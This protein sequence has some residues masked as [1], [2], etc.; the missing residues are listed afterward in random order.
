MKSYLHFCRTEKNLSTNTLE[1][2]R[3]DLTRFASFVGARGLDELTLADLRAYADLLKANGLSNRSISRHVTTMRGLFQFAVEEGALAGNPAELLSS[4]AIG[5]SLPKYLPGP[6]VDQLLDA[7]RLDSPTGLR[8]RAMV[9]LLYA[10]GMR[11]SE[12]IALRVA[13][14]DEATG[15][16]RVTGKG[17]KQ[18]LVPVGT[19]ALRTVSE[20]AASERNSLL[21][22]RMSPYLFVTARGTSMTR[23]AFWKLLR[24]R[25]KTAGIF[26][27]L[28]PHV[29][30]HTF[31]THLLEGGADLRS[32]QT[33][34]GH[35]DIGT[36]QIYT[37]VL[38]SRLEQTVRQHHPRNKPRGEV[39]EQAKQGIKE[40][41]P[42]SDYMFMLDSHLSSEQSRVLSLV[43]DTAARAN[44]NLFLTGGAMR[45]M[46]GG[47]AIRDLDFTVEGNALKLAKTIAEESGAKILSLDEI[48]NPWNWNFP[49]VLRQRSPWR[50][51]KN[52]RNREA[53][54]RFSRA[55]SMKTCAAAISRSTPSAC[56][57]V[58][59]RMACF[60]I[61]R[62]GWRIWNAKELQAVSNYTLYDDPSR[63]LRLIRFRVRLSLQLSE[64]TMSQY[65][66]VREAQLKQKS[67]RSLERELRQIAQEP[68]ALEILQALEQEKL[69]TLFR[70]RSPDPS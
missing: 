13:D 4:P 52:I 49:A 45:D 47:F 9:D 41:K 2:Y 59:P 34:L 21:K 7:S 33:M 23:Q 28:S 20:Y 38:R 70:P 60:S 57:S 25:G 66:N 48:R 43:R 8:D 44:M 18:R 42:M 22:G 46:L 15:V 12:L 69:L 29:L 36:T 19:Q 64:R 17:R 55:P 11:V 53:S 27:N 50:G 63:I 68:L 31:A 14:L 35:S 40:N 24:Q 26:Q 39:V 56:P 62:M 5:Q 58:K 51:R 30:R 32:V 1:S 6:K 37:H 67:R 54:R 10:T 65:Q 3:R 16:V 61:L